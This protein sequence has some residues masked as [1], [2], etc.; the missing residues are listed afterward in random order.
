M[1]GLYYED[2][3]VIYFRLTLFLNCHAHSVGVILMP[4]RYELPGIYARRYNNVM[5]QQYPDQL[6]YSLSKQIG[7][8]ICRF[9]ET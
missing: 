4:Q 3:S 9:Q 8:C 6:R 5:A 1:R 2:E 7:R